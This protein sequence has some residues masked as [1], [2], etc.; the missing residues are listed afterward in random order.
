VSYIAL[1]IDRYSRQ[2]SSLQIE[3]KS[4][5]GAKL[6][7][8]HAAIAHISIPVLHSLWDP[9]TSHVELP[10]SRVR[11]KTLRSQVT[12]LREA[13][14]LSER[15]DIDMRAYGDPIAQN[16]MRTHVA[17]IQTLQQW[18]GT[19]TSHAYTDTANFLTSRALQEETRP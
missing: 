5:K 15:R 18:L 14:R 10:Y 9:C 16:M 6:K 7:G 2:A 11:L 17:L 8:G 12:G 1:L 19:R 3:I 4:Q 13:I